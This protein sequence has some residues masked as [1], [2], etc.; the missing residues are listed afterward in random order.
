MRVFAVSDVHIDYAENRQWLFGLSK[1]DYKNDILILAGDITNNI[2]VI[3]KAFVSLKNCFKEVLYIPGNHD[4]WVS[5]RNNIRNSIDNFHLIKTVASNCGVRMEPAHFK[6]LSIIPLFG[7]YDYSFGEPSEK[8]FDIWIDYTACQWPEG[9]DE[10]S[11]TRYFIA[12]N[13]PYLNLKN[14]FIISFSHFV[15][16]IDVMPSFI[17]E[18][19]KILYPVLGTVLLE[20]Q[21]RQISP[22]IH[23]YG[24]SHVNTR[25]HFNNT[26]YIN[27]AYG[28]PSETMITAKRLLKI[29]EM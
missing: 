13:E 21:I 1:T 3:I 8:I 24:H 27:N 7:W 19:K 10:I 20:K 12:M 25:A 6:T 28:Y 23:I 22:N 14:D 26:E 5:R 2:P 15:P 9:Y 4:L 29:Y 11:V 17:P 18:N 16:R